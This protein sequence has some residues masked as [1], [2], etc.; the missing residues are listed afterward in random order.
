MSF[1]FD[2]TKDKLAAI[3]PNNKEIDHWLEAL[4]IILPKYQITTVPRVAAFLAQTAHESGNYKILKEGLNYRADRLRKV[5]PKYFP[6]DILAEQYA[7]KCADI[8]N[9]VYAN[10][11]GNGNEASGDGFRFSGKGV[12]QITGKNNYVAF[13]KSIGMSLAD[14]PDYLLTF[15]GAIDSACWFWNVNHL[16]ECADKN[17]IL[18]MTKRINGGTIGL[19]ERTT[20]FNNAL[21]VL[22]K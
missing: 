7:T 20:N 12:I 17:D 13:S 22:G 10:R 11:M 19:T 16:N 9:R 14:V 1:S 3:I 21:R 6:T 5:F 15:K 18:T 8:A 4:S 2:F